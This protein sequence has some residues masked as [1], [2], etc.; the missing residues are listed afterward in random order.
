[1]DPMG[2]E[3]RRQLRSTAA[4]HDAGIGSWRALVRRWCDP[5]SSGSAP[6]A[7]FDLLGV[8]SR[9]AFLKVGGATL[10][11]ATVL[12]AC[13]DTSDPEP[14]ADPVGTLGRPTTTA[15][16]DLAPLR[17]EETSLVLL[18][19]ATSLE[20]LHVDV[21]RKTLDAGALGSPGTLAAIRMFEHHHHDHADA[22][23]QATVEHGGVAYTKP[24]E[25]V[26]RT[27]VMP[28]LPL[29]G[30]E[31]SVVRFA[32]SLESSAAS[33][34]AHAAATLTD[35]ADRRTMMRI[36]GVEARH[37]AVLQ[38]LLG[39]APAAGRPGAFLNTDVMGDDGDGRVPDTALVRD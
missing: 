12:A 25:V 28:A 26:W 20:L 13:A 18:R 19:T 38:R 27:V 30:D 32:R 9:R 10:L 23:Q 33:T 15:P 2:D 3:L 31:A 16:R 5:A 17:P 34:Y 14:S 8:S 29:L 24:N 1:M 6:D 7:R 35:P 4:A 36:G 21:Y 39:E 11:T 22:L 37:A